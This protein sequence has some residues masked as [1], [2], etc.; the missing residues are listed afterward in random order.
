VKRRGRQCPASIHVL[1]HI[2]NE[3]ATIYETKDDHLHHEPR[4]TGIAK[5]SKEVIDDI[6][7]K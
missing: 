3:C 4:S 1:Y 6:C 7:S 2:E 5:E